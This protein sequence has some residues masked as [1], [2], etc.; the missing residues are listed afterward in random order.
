MV[1]SNQEL[2]RK[3]SSVFI[4]VISALIILGS[5]ISNYG[6]F[7]Y[8]KLVNGQPNSGSNEFQYYE[9]GKYA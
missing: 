1:V 6:Y 3:E 8:T 4:A 2:V 7:G 9:F 5:S